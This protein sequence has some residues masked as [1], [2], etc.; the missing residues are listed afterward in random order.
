MPLVRIDLTPDRSAAE[1]NA[2]S[3]AIHT[4]LSETMDVPADDL[5]HVVTTS[6]ALRYDR[7]YL[8]VQRSERLVMVQVFLRRGRTA[9]QKRAFYAR[10]VTLL[11]EAGVWPGDLLCVLTENGPEDWSFG[12]GIAQYAPAT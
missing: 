10:A 3:A 7:T 2:I 12:D 6:G 1:Q 4:A 5:F 8:G 9:A 11:A